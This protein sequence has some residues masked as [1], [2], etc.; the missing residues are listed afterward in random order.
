MNIQTQTYIEQAISELKNQIKDPFISTQPQI[1]R[2]LAY[3][4]ARYV[5]HITSKLQVPPGSNDIDHLRTQARLNVNDEITADSNLTERLIE[6]G[7]I[8]GTI[9]KAWNTIIPP[10]AIGTNTNE[11]IQLFD[12]SEY[13]HY[14]NK[15]EGILLLDYKDMM[16]G[17]VE[18]NTSCHTQH[19]EPLIESLIIRKILSFDKINIICNTNKLENDST[20]NLLTDIISF[21]N[22]PKQYLGA[23]IIRLFEDD[24]KKLQIQTN[25]S[26]LGPIL[27][28]K[29]HILNIIFTSAG[30]DASQTSKAINIYNTFNDLHA[31]AQAFDTSTSESL[32]LPELN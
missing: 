17:H 5:P 13:H 3:I 29:E 24:E 16:F 11:N 1:V 25:T 14:Y 30:L 28:Y 19:L 31:T 2:D 6:H 18:A 10:V 22:L 21:A 4:I 9:N 27:E 15:G 20:I 26:M 32:N 7:L 8:V 12:I 23:I